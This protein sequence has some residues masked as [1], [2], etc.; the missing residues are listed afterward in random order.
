MYQNRGAAD[1]GGEGGLGASG[2]PGTEGTRERPG[3]SQAA[4][5]PALRTPLTPCHSRPASPNV[6]AP[7]LRGPARNSVGDSS[8]APAAPAPLQ[9]GSGLLTFLPPRKSL[10]R[11]PL[12]PLQSPPSPHGTVDVSAPK[13]HFQALGESPI[14]V[15]G[16]A[17]D[18]ETW[19]RGAA[20][21]RAG[22][23]PANSLN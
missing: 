11:V 6:P 5:P 13:V 15:P 16:R 7:D 17:W 4:R 8:P 20:A 2:C 19:Q 10:R 21:G 3:S 14:K 18:S 1:R 9:R 22:I 12:R 23:S